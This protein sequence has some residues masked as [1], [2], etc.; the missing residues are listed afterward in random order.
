MPSAQVEEY[1]KTI[2]DIA[3]KHGAARTTE[4]AKCLKISPE[5]VTEAVQHM[6]K[7]GPVIYAPYKGLF[8]QRKG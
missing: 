6:A 3:G 5:S 2:Y 7:K 1:L 4:I 8:S